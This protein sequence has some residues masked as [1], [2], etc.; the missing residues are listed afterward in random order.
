MKILHKNKL[1]LIKILAAQ[2]P[3]VAPNQSVLL[4]NLKFK[5]A[6]NSDYYDTI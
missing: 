2:Q 6:L 3:F 4:N 5:S 1:S